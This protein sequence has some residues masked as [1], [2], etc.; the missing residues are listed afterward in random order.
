MML[1]NGQMEG[2]KR[3]LGSVDNAKREQLGELPFLSG[4]PTKIW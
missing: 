4:K 2:A 3:S 1:L